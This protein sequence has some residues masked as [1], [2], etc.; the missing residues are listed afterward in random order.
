MSGAWGMNGQMGS[1]ALANSNAYQN[2]ALH[3]TPQPSSDMFG[4]PPGGGGGLVPRE[5]QHPKPTID[6]K[7]PL[8]QMAMG[9]AMNS[10]QPRSGSGMQAPQHNMGLHPLGTPVRNPYGL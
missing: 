5:S 1:G 8:A 3:G 2:M 10:L 4:V 9:M 6:L 7:N